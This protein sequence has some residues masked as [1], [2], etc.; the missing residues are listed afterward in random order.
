MV[1]CYQLL[2]CP[3]LSKAASPDV[4][5]DLIFNLVTVLLDPRL[6]SLEEGP[7]VRRA[8]NVLVVK[9]VNKCDPTSIMRLVHLLHCVPSR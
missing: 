2:Q 9:I 7:Q 4:L 8:V 3:S 6:N 5:K 1:L